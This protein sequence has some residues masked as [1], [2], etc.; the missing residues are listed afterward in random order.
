MLESM[1]TIVKAAV[2]PGLKTQKHLSGTGEV[3]HSVILSM[4]ITTDPITIQ[5]EQFLNT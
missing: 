5:R 4:N 1:E 3:S 2:K